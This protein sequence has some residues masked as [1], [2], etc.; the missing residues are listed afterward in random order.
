MRQ[1]DF[2]DAMRII[3]KM[4]RRGYTDEQA[5]K[6]WPAIK[7][8][9]NAAIHAAV[10]KVETDFHPDML[11][12]IGKIRDIILQEGKHIREE[13]VQEREREAQ[14]M[15]AEEKR[16]L[17]DY[18]PKGEFEKDAFECMIFC[19]GDAK[20]DEKLKRIAE[21]ARKYPHREYSAVYRDTEAFYREKGLIGEPGQTERM[22]SG[23]D[24]RGQA[25]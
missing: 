18:R 19:A 21:M 7:D 1:Q 5:A 2:I 11:V 24:R 3:S 9:P 4:F 10:M 22:D 25:A 13:Q 14:R 17:Y 16:T 6:I 8:E 12:P 15:K 20:P 23:S